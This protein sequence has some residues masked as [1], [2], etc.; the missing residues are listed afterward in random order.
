MGLPI[1][2]FLSIII[3]TATHGLDN[4]L[5]RC[6]IK[7]SSFFLYMAVCFAISLTPAYNF[8]RYISFHLIFAMIL[9]SYVVL[10]SMR[11]K[12]LLA[13]KELT[14][15][16]F[17]LLIFMVEQILGLVLSNIDWFIYVKTGSILLFCAFNIDRPADSAIC[18][19]FGFW[20]MQLLLALR[21]LCFD[22][23][24]Y[25][26]FSNV[27]IIQISLVCSVAAFILSY[28][29]RIAKERKKVKQ[30]ISKNMELFTSSDKK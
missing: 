27:D 18:T 17:V 19:S 11:K 14:F 28:I 15:L 25:F 10:I 7:K 12:T 3:L 21:N 29:T 22:S 30:D 5:K 13:V 8:N 9:I 26:D 2:I 24:I 23:Y 1:V 16:F 20:L 4:V 6:K